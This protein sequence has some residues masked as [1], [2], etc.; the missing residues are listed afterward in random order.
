MNLAEALRCPA[1]MGRI[2]VRPVASDIPK[3]GDG[4][5]GDMAI[6]EKKLRATGMKVGVGEAPGA[7]RGQVFGIEK[8]DQETRLGNGVEANGRLCGAGAV[9][10]LIEAVVEEVSS[11]AATAIGGAEPECVARVDG[12]IGSPREIVVAG[13]LDLT[14]ELDVPALVG[15]AVGGVGESLRRKAVVVVVGVEPGGEPPFSE[16]MSAG[17]GAGELN[18]TMGGGDQEGGEK[19][20][21]QNHGEQFDECECLGRRASV[22]GADAASGDGEHGTSMDRLFVALPGAPGMTHGRG[23]RVIPKKNRGILLLPGLAA[24]K[25]WSPTVCC[26]EG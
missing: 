7:D 20:E 4:K 23:A 5:A 21:D 25:Y 18:G 16:V 2:G 9:H 15:M 12:R 11:V 22:T 3:V 1:K 13:G 14:R 26:C 10:V 24:W 19:A 6:E 17:D 8:P